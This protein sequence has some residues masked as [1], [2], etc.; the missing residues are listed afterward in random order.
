MLHKNIAVVDR[1]VIEGKGFIAQDLIKKGEVVSR[2][3]PNQPTYTIAEVLAMPQEE[4]DK[5]LHYAYQYREDALVNEQGD[6]R[7]MNHSCD[8]NIVWADDDTMIASRDILPGEE[9]TFDY[10][11]T[12]VAIPFRME[13]R[14]GSPNCR[15]IITNLDYR[16]PAWQ[17]KYGDKLPRH[18]LKAIAEWKAQQE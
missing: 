8:P 13:C 2:L 11:M 1:G 18:T 7:F 10:A 14:C 16:D 5:L 12:E 15:G 17:A 4:Q 6:E 3:E 9:I